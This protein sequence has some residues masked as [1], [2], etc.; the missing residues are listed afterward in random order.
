MG[1][2]EP[3]A[4]TAVTAYILAQIKIHDRERYDRYAA[5]FFPTLAPFEGRLLSA[6]E[7]PL[8]LEGAWDGQKAV[9]IAF[10]DEALALAWAQSEAYRT[11]SVDREA[12]TE[13]T[14][15][16]LRGIG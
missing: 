16:L 11:I 1:A 6:D 12:A 5:G 2:L 7:G 9:L 3:T 8:V 15:L 13:G 4:E 14:V 10:P